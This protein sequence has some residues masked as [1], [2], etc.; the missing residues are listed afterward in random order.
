MNTLL[1]KWTRPG[2]EL[3]FTRD[4]MISSVVDPYDDGL[5]TFRHDYL[6]EN[7]RIQM[8]SPTVRDIKNAFRGE[9]RIIVITA[10]RM[11]LESET[12]ITNW[13]RG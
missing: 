9:L 6:M 1:G 8:Y 7:N 10:D 2:V 11:V 12:G 5:R 13:N 3:N 4:K